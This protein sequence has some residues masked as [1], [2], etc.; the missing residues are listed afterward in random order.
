MDKARIAKTM[1]LDKPIR[2]T[3]KM[4][5]TTVIDKRLVIIDQYGNEMHGVV[6]LEVIDG[7][8]GRYKVEFAAIDLEWMA[9]NAQGKGQTPQAAVPLDPQVGRD[10][11]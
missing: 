5:G 2:W 1:G 10:G 4:E 7:E 6:S 3:V 8:E 9:P 11:D